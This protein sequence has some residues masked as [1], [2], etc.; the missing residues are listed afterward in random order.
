L[1]QVCWGIAIASSKSPSL[2]HWEVCKAVAKAACIL[3]C[4]FQGSD[5]RGALIES[6]DATDNLSTLQ[7]LHVKE[8][9]A[10]TLRCVQFQQ[11]FECS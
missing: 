4:V 9:R 10:T 11:I 8:R 1:G 5:L 7:K 2:R 6:P 3:D